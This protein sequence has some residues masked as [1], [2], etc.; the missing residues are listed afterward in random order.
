MDAVLNNSFQSK[1]LYQKFL[2]LLWRKAEDVGCKNSGVPWSC[3]ASFELYT[4][5]TGFAQLPLSDFPFCHPQAPLTD[6]LPQSL[7]PVLIIPSKLV[8]CSVHLHV[9]A[10]SWN[11]WKATDVQYLNNPVQSSVTIT[12]SVQTQKELFPPVAIPHSRN[13]QM[14]TI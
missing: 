1:Q 9:Q 10:I 3:K 12:L 11:F 7:T 8:W 13:I 6:W 4:A 2:P 14:L 5:R